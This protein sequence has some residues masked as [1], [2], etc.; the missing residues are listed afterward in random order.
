MARWGSHMADMKYMETSILY[1]EFLSD[2]SVLTAIQSEVVVL[3]GVLCSGFRAPGLWHLRGLARLLGARR[4]GRDHE[5]VQEDVRRVRTAVEE[6]VKWWGAEEMVQRVGL[7]KWPGVDDV[8]GELGGYG[9]D[10]F[11]GK[12]A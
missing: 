2:H 8:V 4:D 12:G 10:A 7:A 9:D 1:G 3:I 5:G 11:D 6:C